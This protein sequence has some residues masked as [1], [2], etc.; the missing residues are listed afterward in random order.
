MFQS[1]ESLA[2]RRDLSAPL[3]QRKVS[4]IRTLNRW[5]TLKLGAYAMRRGDYPAFVE[6]YHAHLAL[7]AGQRALQEAIELALRETSVLLCF[8]RKPKECH[9]TTARERNAK[10]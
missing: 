4:A 9:R 8:E 1:P 5:A 10:A 6:I 3:L 7:E 2:S